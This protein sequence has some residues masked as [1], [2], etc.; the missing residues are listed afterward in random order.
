MTE[1]RLI[2]HYTAGRR[3]ALL[4]RQACH[5][6]SAEVMGDGG[7]QAWLSSGA[8]AF[9]RTD[10]AGVRRFDTATP[11]VDPTL[12]SRVELPG[13]WNLDDYNTTQVRSVRMAQMALY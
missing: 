3:M 4:L 1:P 6:A 9:P 7:M 5:G 10:A 8:D 11:A 12:L 2:C 13:G